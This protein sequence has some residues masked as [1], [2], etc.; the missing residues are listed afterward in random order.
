MTCPTAPVRKESPMEKET[1]MPEHHRTHDKD[2]G[3]ATTQ[4]AI[5][6]LF[7]AAFEIV[8]MISPF[9]F[10]FYAVYNPLLLALDQSPITRWLTAFFLPHMIVPPDD[11][12]ILIRVLGSVLF[13]GGMLVFLVCAGQVYSGKLL[14]KAPATRGLYAF[15]RHPQYLALACAAVG[16]AIMWPRFLTLVLLAIMLLLYYVLARDEEH[17]MTKQFGESYRGYVHKSGMFIPRPIERMFK[18]NS[19]PEQRW[20][21][22]QVSALFLILLAGIVGT[23]FLLRVYTIHHLPLRRMNNVDVLTIAPQDSTTA[24]ELLPAVLQD[25]V[26]S[27]RLASIP[28][29]GGHRLLAYFIPVD[30]VM[31]GMIANT[32][33]EWKLFEQH[34]TFGMIVDYILHPFAHLAGDHAHHVDMSAM[35]HGPEMYA[36][37]AMKRRV[38]F[39]DVASESNELTSPVDDFGINA[40]RTPLFFVDVHLHT[41]EILQVRETPTGSGWGTVPTPLF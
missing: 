7:L 35:R 21:A 23:G 5:V 20:A 37:P 39:I 28:D 30:Y 10:Y 4:G 9:A 29:P 34:K 14:K 13:V 40:R 12:L 1:Q 22:G 19:D 33:D 24:L 2:I 18:W 11:V 32:G 36:L 15:V 17:R 26:V 31:Q 38:I 3:R 27:S 8:I 6:L 16:L 25:S 41:A